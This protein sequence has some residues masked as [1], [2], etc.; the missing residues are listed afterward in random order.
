MSRRLTN[1]GLPW[2][3]YVAGLSYIA[4]AVFFFYLTLWGPAELLGFVATYDDGMVIHSVDPDTE[5]A[6][7]GLRAGDRVLMMN[8]LPIRNVRD[9]TAANGNSQAGRTERWLVVRGNERITL[10]ITPIPK[11]LGT[12]LAQG[13]AQVISL[14]LTGYFLGF[15]IAWKRPTDPVARIGAWFIITV[16][17]APGLPMGWAVLWRSLPALLQFLM[18]FPQISRFVLEGIFLSF[19]ALFPRRIAQRRWVWFAIWVPVLITLPWR[20]SAF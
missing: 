5:V 10:E 18:W 8:D 6:K 15:L 11:S 16:S 14:E 17:I 1:R 12:R 19:F 13:Y 9:W 4:N 2:W 20:F 3:M 7:G